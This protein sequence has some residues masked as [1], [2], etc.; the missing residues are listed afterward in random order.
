MSDRVQLPPLKQQGLFTIPIWRSRVP[1]VYAQHAQMKRDIIGQYQ[2]GD[3]PRHR[4]GYGH[5]SPGTVFYAENIQRFPYF[6][7]LKQAFIRNVEQ[8]LRQRTGLAAAMPFEVSAAL[9]WVLVQN[10]EQWVN[11][12]WHDHYPATI[13]GCYYLQVP[14]TEDESEGTL[15][16]QRPGAQDMFVEHIERIRP[17]EG[18][19]IL[20]PSHL[21]HR[22]EPCPS[23]RDLRISINMDAYVHWRHAQEE[24]RPPMDLETFRQAL[25]ES[26]GA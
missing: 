14:D 24:G 11:G 20:F 21:W 12:T 3:Y 25:R 7:L 6:G 5:Q 16:F 2:R 8:I 18:E 17:V 15:A 9:A 26:L 1:R 22:P 4:H 13:S 19:F 23:A 10:N